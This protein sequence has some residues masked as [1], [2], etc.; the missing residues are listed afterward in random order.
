MVRLM[1][2]FFDIEV[3]K[4][5]DMGLKLCVNTVVSW[6]ELDVSYM[7]HFGKMFEDE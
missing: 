6:K 2:I 3:D 7:S 5:I 1:E 4:V